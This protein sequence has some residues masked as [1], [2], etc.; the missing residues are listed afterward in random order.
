MSRRYLRSLPAI[1]ATVVLAACSGGDG[2]TA[3]ATSEA[4]STSEAGATGTA[5]P[6]GEATPASTAA[7]TLSP[8]EIFAQ[9]SPSIAFIDTPL[10]TGSAI[11]IEEEWLVSNAHVVWPF[12]EVR[13]VFGDGTEFVDAPVFAWD[14]MADLSVIRLPKGHGIPAVEFDDP[15]LLPTGSELFLIGYPA[16]NE[17]FPQ[18]T[19]SGGVLSRVRTW[20]LAELPYIQTDAA[21]TGG[22]SGGALVSETG[23]VVGLSGFKFA[24]TFGL[25]LSAPVVDT[26]ARGLIEGT[27]VNS[28]SDRRLAR[29]GATDVISFDLMN[30]YDQQ[31]FIVREPI[32]T[33]VDVELNGFN[34]G[35]IDIYDT[36]GLYINTADEFSSGAEVITF[37]IDFG[38]PFIVI[39]SQFTLAT[40]EFEISASA[41]LALQN[42][43]DDRRLL[44][45][46]QTYTAAMDYPADVDMF[47]IDLEAGETVT[48]RVESINFDADLVIDDPDNTGEALAYDDDGGGG[49]FG[50]DSELTFTAPNTAR[51]I[52]SVADV[53][54]TEVGGYYLIID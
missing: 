53:N 18:P 32:G 21:I 25:A 34:D 30:Y 28:L 39:A 42:D 35:V 17:E 29:T 27:D 9:V 1:L 16:E 22:Q 51:F 2:S 54:F 43:P 14:L 37:E 33:T 4:T 36:S 24:D 6:T 8:A 7:T 23:H 47:E 48:I 5:G 19:I 38:I 3:T 26:R 31:A 52:V 13:V 10:G 11:L 46:G 41:E 15:S 20:D 12:E 45:R 50:T 44:R 49:F 40:G